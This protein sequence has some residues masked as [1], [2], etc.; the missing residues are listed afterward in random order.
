MMTN[1]YLFVFLSRFFLIAFTCIF[2]SCNSLRKT[3]SMTATEIQL[4]SDRKGHTLHNTQ[5]F[6]PDDTWIVYDSRNIDSAIASTNTISMVNV[7][8][9]EIKKL[10]ETES[11]TQ[12]G[13]GVGAAT[14]SPTEDKIIFIHGVRNS[15]KDKPYGITRRT[16][17]G[18]SVLNPFQPYF[19]DARDITPPFTPGALRG[20]THAHSWSGDGKWI[21]FTYND[22][23]IEKLSI[24]DSSIVDRRTVGV[25]IPKK[26]SIEDDG[27]NEN[28]SGEMFSVVVAEITEKPTW[29][30]DEIDRAFDEGW[31][32]KNGYQ[33]LDGTRQEKAI[34]FQGDTRNREGKTI[35]E[36]FVLELPFDLKVAQPN[37]RLEG[38]V[39]TRP[40]VPKGVVQR[41]VT[42]SKKGVL[43]PRHWL[44]TTADGGLI[45]FLSEDD[46]G[47]VQIYAISPQG[48]ESTQL[49]KNHSSVQGSFHFSPDGRY[50]AYPADDDLFVTN[51]LT[52]K[53]DR[54]TNLK[55]SNT[56]PIGA[57]VWSNQGDKI[58]YN[59]YVKS[60]NDEFL[61]IFVLHLKN[62]L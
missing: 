51:I 34:A 25:M 30:T 16:G 50:I 29:G 60:G 46:S 55:L 57:P 45:A 39:N 21:S 40:N 54:L 2:I 27:T 7:D 58:A 43:G 19:M 28:N 8:T 15:S 18:I 20:G 61:Q 4:T 12:Y 37:K 56:R 6:S 44:R 48:G 23:I 49:T 10:Y 5:V 31:I 11:P 13:P 42:Y 1:S 22:Y 41:R 14:F 26:V 32:G 33:K 3:P 36:L 38:T 9:K 59:R 47:Y 62:H 24:I 53:T 17:V 35:T 52:G